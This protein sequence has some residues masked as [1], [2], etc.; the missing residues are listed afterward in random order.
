[1]ANKTWIF[2]GIGCLIFSLALAFIIWLCK[3]VR[4]VRKPKS[5]ILPMPLAKVIDPR[6]IF[7]FQIKSFSPG[8]D[9]RAPFSVHETAIYD[10]SV[11]SG[12]ISDKDIP[13]GG[14]ALLTLFRVKTLPVEFTL[15]YE[16]GDKILKTQRFRVEADLTVTKI[17]LP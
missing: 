14:H 8:D 2:D 4:L 1:M 9:L 15:Q 7:K 6:T 11:G 12:K 10:I 5:T 17:N 13:K 3:T 16:L